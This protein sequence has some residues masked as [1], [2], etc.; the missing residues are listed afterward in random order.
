VLESSSSTSSMKSN[1]TKLTVEEKSKLRAWL[2]EV[3]RACGGYEK[4]GDG[5]IG[6]VR[7]YAC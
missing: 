7:A 2:I 3:R 5:V 4:I 6:G 1:G